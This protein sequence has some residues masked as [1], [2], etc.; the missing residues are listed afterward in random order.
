M[1]EWKA[2]ANT[3]LP[4]AG[5][6]VLS[7]EQAA[8]L[9]FAT[10]HLAD[11]GA[12]VIRVQSHNRP[13]PPPS[14][15]AD[16]TRNKRQ[17]AIDLSLPGGPAVFLKV[18]AACDVVAHN[19][20]PRVMR[21]YGIDYAGVR[22]LNPKVVYVSLTGYGTNGPWGERPLFGPGAEAVS[23]H[24]LLIGDP[25]AWPGRPGTIVYADNTCGLYCAYAVLAALD[26][27]DRGGEGQH[28]DISLYETSVSHLGPAI[29][30]RAFGA[31]LP[32]RSANSDAGWAVHGV[33]GARGHDRHVALAARHDQLP[34][35]S[36]ALGVAG[37]LPEVNVALRV[38]KMGAEEAVERLQR[39]G[40]A[41]AAVADSSGQLADDHLWSRGFFGLMS[42]TVPGFEGHYPHGGPAWGGGPGLEMREPRPVGANSRAILRDVA[43]LS[44]AEV[45]AA[46]AAGVSGE[47]PS[48]ATPRPVAADA[49]RLGLERGEL[50]RVDAAFDGWK[51]ARD[52]AGL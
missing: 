50:S 48:A 19:F 17:L 47:G 35:L 37:S 13:A 46:F 38:S 15:E 12:E 28:I 7:M 2:F 8:A 22:A 43:G 26:E 14:V 24:N 36:A 34:A 16:P 9:P 49:E 51:A 33:F 1:T 31:P 32:A 42:R 5:V 18:A 41:A 3:D 23:G 11:L 10:R 25:A 27:R 40:I 30:E 4:L 45:D 29:A 20:T 52:R 6:R 39:A 21:R 44:D